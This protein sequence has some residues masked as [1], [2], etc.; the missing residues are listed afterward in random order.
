MCVLVHCSAAVRLHDV[1]KLQWFWQEGLHVCVC[2]CVCL[3]TVVLLSAYMTSRNCSGFGR[4]GWVSVEC[5]SFSEPS[6]QVFA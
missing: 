4:K 2:A 6:K 3:C 1:Q 5:K